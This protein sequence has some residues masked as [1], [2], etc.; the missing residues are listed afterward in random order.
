VCHLSRAAEKQ[1]EKVCVAVA[2]YKQA[3]TNAVEKSISD[4]GKRISG[5]G[6]M[7]SAD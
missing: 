3:I 2:F 4:P 6:K 5:L 1:K 7:H